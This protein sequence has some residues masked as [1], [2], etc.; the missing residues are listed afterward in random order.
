MI[1]FV[2]VSCA[3]TQKPQEN[4]GGLSEAEKEEIVQ[5]NADTLFAHLD[6]LEVTKGYTFWV[7]AAKYLAYAFYDA[8][9]TLI[10]SADSSVYADG[11]I[12]IAFVDERGNTYSVLMGPK[13]Q[14]HV[15][16]DE[17]GNVVY[18]VEE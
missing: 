9:N 15:I 4:G 10:V 11:S 16:Y 5:A 18:A 17:E 2:L 12:D 7:R 14:F 6:E 3:D 1:A 13:G 8:S